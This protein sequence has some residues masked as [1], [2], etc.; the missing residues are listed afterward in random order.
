MNA[1]ESQIIRGLQ[2][3]IRRNP[4]YLLSAAFMA[5]G[6]RL[7]LVGPNDPTGDVRLIVVTLVALQ[8]YEWAVGGIL[9]VLF[10]A[11]RSPEDRPSL[12]M[13]AALFWTGP[14]AATLEMI[15][16][17]PETGIYVAMGA[18]VIALAEL[19]LCARQ[20]GV[21]LSRPAE[22]VGAACVILLACAAPLIRIPDSDSGLNETYLYAAWWVFACIVLG[23]VA[24]IR[25]RG[26][27]GGVAGGPSQDAAGTHEFC[28]L[29]L[30]ITACVVHL[31]GMNYGFFCHAAY[32]YASPL[33]IA[34]SIVGF[35]WAASQTRGKSLATAAAFILPIIAI[36][37]SLQPF[38]AR[39]PVER[40][41]V[42]VRD[43]RIGILAGAAL[44]WWYGCVRLR[45]VVLLHAGNAAC[46]MAALV[47]AQRYGVIQ[48]HVS[49]DATSVAFAFY[50]VTGY[51]LMVA[52]VRRSR[53][54][55]IVALLTHLLATANMLDG[56]GAQRS[57]FVFILAGWSA[58]AAIHLAFRH[59][60]LA[61]RFIIIVMLTTIPWLLDSAR[62]F[63][64]EI[65]LHSAGL[66][67]VLLLIGQIWRWTGY[68]AIAAILIVGHAAC[69]GG[70]WT[71]HSA[72]P[73]ALLCVCAGF[74]MLVGGGLI[75]WHKAGLLQAVS[76]V[77]VISPPVT[78]PTSDASQNQT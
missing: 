22:I 43:P 29:G 65:A 78:P 69:Y 28:F 44:A 15:A 27:S 17:R 10:R 47:A 52:A 48:T 58:L 26:R 38:D 73:T 60:G 39:V 75:S 9:V 54:E 8:V 40:L 7:M 35:E 57:L 6:A 51:L 1:L 66:I 2:W 16:Y 4:T 63:Q 55:A 74:A 11:R 77:E 53:V 49:A 56:A 12:L 76:V 67:A 14:F 3:V 62:L 13:V 70:Y 46:A 45:L 33:L 36:V 41:P 5:I 68:R 20:L 25:S 34:L 23:C 37:L 19:R 30:T 59:P 61:L 42:F 24:A 18:C 31:V 50:A 64:T 32:F 72:Q 21:G 71:L